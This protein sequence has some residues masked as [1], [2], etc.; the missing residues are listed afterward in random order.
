MEKTKLKAFTLMEVTVA[1]LISAICISICYSAYT[2]VTNYY[3][4]FRDKNET[5]GT[6]MGLKQVLARDFLRGRIVLSTATGLE[7]MLDSTTV[8][9]TFKEDRV[10]RELTNLHT[11]T[12]KLALTPPVFSFEQKPIIGPDTID[13]VKFEVRLDKNQVVPLLVQKLYSAENLFH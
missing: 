10:L 6:V 2:I 8:I 13:Q 12:F 3:A 1:M 7:V 5:V 4:T 11:D 9:Y